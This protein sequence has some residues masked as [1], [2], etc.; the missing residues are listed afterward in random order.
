MHAS[1][2]EQIA[3]NCRVLKTEEEVAGI[4]SEMADFLQG[5]SFDPA[6]PLFV[7]L[8]ESWAHHE[9]QSACRRPTLDTGI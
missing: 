1:R 4:N 3:F 2:Q 6:N 5:M 9:R 8:C 7:C